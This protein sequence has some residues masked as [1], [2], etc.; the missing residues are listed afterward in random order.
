MSHKER[1]CCGTV[2]VNIDIADA[3]DV[4]CAS[5]AG[6]IA[7]QP[8]LTDAGL[9]GGVVATGAANGPT[10]GGLHMICCCGLL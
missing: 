5:D 1:Y 3:M 2:T 8:W 7:L 9:R 6:A 4:G 10:H